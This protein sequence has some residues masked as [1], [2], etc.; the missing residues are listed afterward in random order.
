MRLLFASILCHLDPS[1]GSALC[2]GELRELLAV[3]GIDC[4]VLTARSL[5]NSYSALAAG[6]R[7]WSNMARGCFARPNPGYRGGTIIVSDSAPGK[8]PRRVSDG[9]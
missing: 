2:P 7:L 6:C 3:R 4:Q 9:E 5:P 1:S 8:G